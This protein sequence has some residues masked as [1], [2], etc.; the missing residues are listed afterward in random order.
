MLTEKKSSPVLI[1]DE[2]QTTVTSLT[3]VSTSDLKDYLEVTHSED[4]TQI[5]SH[6]L[7]AIDWFERITGH[8][9]NEQTR[10][11]IF[12]R[13]SNEFELPSMPVS[14]IDSVD[15]SEEGTKTSQTISN[16]YLYGSSPPCVR[17]KD[18]HSW[19]HPLDSVEITYT[20]GYSDVGDVPP[21]VKEMLKKMVADLYESRSSI[22]EESGTPS[23]LPMNWKSML[24]PYSVIRL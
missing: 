7:T 8:M 2:H 22:T 6:L 20:A 9:V 5:D 11:A 18:T 24:F 14:S 1:S 21:G 19:G 15:A 17:V 16:F 4:D 23:E 12:D 13:E 3:V 10:K